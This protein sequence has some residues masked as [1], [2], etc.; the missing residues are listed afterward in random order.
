MMIGSTIQ[1][2]WTC[3]K[4]LREQST[5]IEQ[6]DHVIARVSAGEVGVSKVMGWIDFCPHSV[7][8]ELFYAEFSRAM[9][10]H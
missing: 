8:F 4:L 10:H 6:T 1:R 3:D 2:R 9:M 5:M 7:V